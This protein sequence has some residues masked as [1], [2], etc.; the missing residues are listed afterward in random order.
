MTQTSNPKKE[1]LRILI[2]DDFQETRRNTR[3]MIATLDNVE[4]VAIASNGRA[5]C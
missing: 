3:L 4:V 2:A 5:G 1:K